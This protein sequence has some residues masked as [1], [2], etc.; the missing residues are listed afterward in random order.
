MK[1]K[2][3]VPVIILFFLFA[4]FPACQK[5]SNPNPSPTDARTK[6]LGT[7]TVTEYKKKASYEV[8]ITADESSSDGVLIYNFGAFGA[9]ITA[10]AFVKANSITLD[11]DQEI[12]PGVI[13]NGGGS[14][15]AT[16][17]ITWTYTINTGADLITVNAKYR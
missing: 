6:F 4:V 3:I 12:V 9:G 17:E 16:P 10:T 8:N 2:G 15:S 1:T 13:I 11:A 7:W 5:E 14:Y